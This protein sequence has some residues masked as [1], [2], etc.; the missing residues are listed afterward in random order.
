MS[1]PSVTLTNVLKLESGRSDDLVALLKHNIEHVVCHLQGW[2]TT[3]LVASADGDS[4]IIHSEWESLDAVEAM[5]SDP[6][7]QAY[8]PQI[9]ACASIESFAGTE[10]FAQSRQH[11][12]HPAGEPA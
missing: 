9:S 10:V 3:R 11:R 4:V 2:K 1:A 8:F 12:H 6:R 5:R 7:M